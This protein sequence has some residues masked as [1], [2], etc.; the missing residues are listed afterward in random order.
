MN[1]I[2]VTMIVK[3]SAGSSG[4]RRRQPSARSIIGFPPASAGGAGRSSRVVL[5]GR[6][7]LRSASC[8]SS[9]V[10]L[11]HRLGVVLRLFEGLVD[12]D[13]AGDRRADLLAD[14]GPEVLEL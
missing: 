12:A 11:P 10:A 14:A 5:I 6:L 8:H 7:Q 2:C 3:I 4:P 9:L 13:L 1:G